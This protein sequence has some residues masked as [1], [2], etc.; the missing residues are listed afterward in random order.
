MG[1]IYDRNCITCCARLVESARPSR[2]HQNAMLA[3]IERGKH[4]PDA[5]LA[6]VRRR[7][8]LELQRPIGSSGHE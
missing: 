4:S 5:V 6:L 2:I 7:A 8:A 1:P 3:F